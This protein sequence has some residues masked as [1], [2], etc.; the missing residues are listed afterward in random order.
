MQITSF[1]L[2]EQTTFPGFDF[3]FRVSIRGTE[4]EIRAVPFSATFGPEPVWAI[5]PAMDGG[6]VLGFLI[7]LPALDDELMFG[8][9]GEPLIAT[10]LDGTISG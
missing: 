6:G 8:F 7:N 2:G 3:P 5:R 4:I 9:L 1:E 10:G